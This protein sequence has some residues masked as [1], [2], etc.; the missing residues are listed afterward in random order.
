MPDDGAA[1]RANAAGG[2]AR[3]RL[4]ERR[5]ALGLTQEALA[6]LMG[7]ERSTIVRWER[8][9][10]EPLPLIR[11]KLARALRVS[12]DRLGELLAPA[13]P[14]AVDGAGGAG[15]PRQLPPAVAGFTGRG[16]ELEALTNVLDS[17]GGGTP[18]AVVI[19]AIGGTAGVGKTALAVQ[20][21]HQ[22]SERFPDGQ[23][24]ANLRGYDPGRPVPAAEALAGFLRALGVDSQDIAGMEDERA[25]RYRSLMAEK[26]IMVVLDN[27]GSVDQVRPL[28]PGSPGCAVL[29][30]SRDM[31]AGLVAR[32]GAT[33]LDLDVLPAADAVS[34]LTALIGSRA[35]T[36]PDATARLADLCCHLPL[37]LRVAAELASVRRAAMLA[38]LVGELAD[39]RKR[40]DLLGAAGDKAT[41]VRAVFSW[42]Y[43]H[44][45]AE[46][47]HAFRLLGLHPGREFDSYSTAALTGSMPDQSRRTL[48]TLTRAHLVQPVGADRYGMHDL[49]RAYARQL[50]T[51]HDSPDEQLAALTRLF[52]HYL[53]TAATAMDTLFPAEGHS[54]P[55]T[56]PPVTPAPP[57][58]DVGA[59]R[60]WLDANRITLTEVAAQ[61][62]G[63]RPGHA[64]RLATVLFRYLDTH[65][66]YH[67][68]V[69][70]STYALTAARLTRDRAAEAS[71]LM[72]L[73]TA[74]WRLNLHSDAETHFGQA[75]TL[76][77]DLGD[78]RGRARALSGL[79]NIES[80]RERY[81]LAADY[82]GQALALFRETGDPLG[83]AGALHRL[84]G[85]LCE[86]GFHRRGAGLLRTAL[87]AYRELGDRH[88]EGGVLAALGIAE[89]QQGRYEQAAGY[90]QQA[91]AVYPTSV[92]AAARRTR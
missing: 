9:E 14:A 91:L 81:D 18:G 20:F 37:A 28:L 92:T 32:D 46:V 67:D 51:S 1:K 60:S 30:T 66:Y 82:H 61:A 31:L 83:Q 23:L 2:A 3:R 29:V 84:G 53:R 16:A 65:G 87:G 22:V 39:L 54:R 45:D 47:A 69:S 7:V 75:L 17:A 13:A 41:Q 27:A 5:K 72:A 58:T 12:A 56:P 52:D 26:R 38:D 49:L 57:L 36:D 76:F 35:D 44:L 19:S 63:N 4:A 88:G 15:V 10:T 64:T 33:R 59:A 42:S 79:G 25:A 34:L 68:A 24:Y 70:V 80:A 86:Q 85:V 90:L 50:A 21:A 77:C 8:G 11:P 6:D 62:A 43:R 78:P 89:W 55:E 74:R 71:A 48:D 73:G 40:L